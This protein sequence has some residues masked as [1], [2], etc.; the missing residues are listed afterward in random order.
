M[1]CSCM[2][3]EYNQKVLFLKSVYKCNATLLESQCGFLLKRKNYFQVYM[4]YECLRVSSRYF[5]NR[6]LVRR[7]L[8]YQLL[9]MNNY[10]KAIIIWTAWCN[11]KKSVEKNT[12]FRSMCENLVYFEKNKNSLGTAL[13]SRF[14]SLLL[15]T[16]NV[17]MIF[18]I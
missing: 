2:G 3:N 15:K 6:I 1:P 10:Y 8:L 17:L 4:K 9:I 16:Y 7:K 14:H 12:E 5:Q 18:R 13:F 11:N